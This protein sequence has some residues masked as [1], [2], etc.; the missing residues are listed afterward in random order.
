MNFENFCTTTHGYLEF[1]FQKI[2]IPIQQIVML[3]ADCNYTYIYLKNGEKFLFARTI[4]F[5]EYMLK[6]YRFERIHKTYMINCAH[7]RNYDAK[8]Q[9]LILS[10]NLKAT[11]SR[12]RKCQLRGQISCLN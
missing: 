10:N 5:F 3:Q 7:I 12:R 9:N 6:D 2:K 11:I 8:S 4:K 1:R